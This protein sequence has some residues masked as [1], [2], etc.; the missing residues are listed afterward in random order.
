[1]IQ[2]PHSQFGPRG[3]GKAGAKL[4][5]FRTHSMPPVDKH[6]VIE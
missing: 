2:S 5:A 6:D 1:M 4:G 3:Y